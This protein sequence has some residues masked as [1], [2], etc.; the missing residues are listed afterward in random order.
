MVRCWLPLLVVGLLLTVYAS[1]MAP[2]LCWA[3][4][5]ADGGDLVTAVALGS[6]PHPPGFPT[7]TLLGQLFV[8]LPWGTP[9]G[10]LNLMSAVLAA[11]AA[12]LTA[13]A[14]SRLPDGCSPIAALCAGLCVG[15]APLFWSQGLITEV[16]ST[17]AF[18]SAAVILLLIADVPCWALGLAWG[19]GLAAHPTVLFLTPFVVQGAWRRSRL[20]NRVWSAV[21][22]VLAAL[23]TWTSLYGVMLVTRSPGWSPWADL[24]TMEGVLTLISAPLY[25]GYVFSLPIADWP[26]RLLGLVGILA[27]QFTPVGALLAGLGWTS[28]RKKQPRLAASSLVSFAI[29]CLYAVGY[30]TTDSLVYLVPGLPLTAVWLALG[31]DRIGGWLGK[32]RPAGR[33][34]IPLLPLLQLL[35]LW[36]PMDVS[37]DR[38]ALAW[39]DEVLAKAPPQAVLLTARDRHTFTLWYEH[40]VLGKRSD[41]AV[42]DRDLWSWAP[43][44]KMVLDELKLSPADA[45]RA[46][47][48]VE[49]AAQSGRPIIEVYGGFDVAS[50]G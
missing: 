5:G 41:V 48:P 37:E 40:E 6:V 29:L 14:I 15:L 50:E 42:I 47:S 22:A 35:F 19:M 21:T 43:Y 13:A 8:Q 3:H 28:L 49:A 34:L 23:L 25:R 26:Q 45:H 7:Y 1:T 27:R 39:A 20:S 12:G 44:R 4:Q 16:Y 17:A 32:R 46:F 11:G 30:D 10:R 9:A 31:L 36:G 18:F 33:W 38:T 24:S 2:G